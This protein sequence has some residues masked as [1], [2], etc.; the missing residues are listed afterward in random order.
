MKNEKFCF[1]KG[2]GLIALVG[3]LLVGFVLA[4]QMVTD[5]KTSINSRAGGGTAPSSVSI[6]VAG[7]LILSELKTKAA[8][9]LAVSG[10]AAA[11]TN[12]M[13]ALTTV[14]TQIGSSLTAVEGLI[15]EINNQKSEKEG[16]LIN[17]KADETAKKAV[18][19]TAKKTTKSAQTDAD[20]VAT[21]EEVYKKQLSD[22][23]ENLTVTLK[24]LS[25][26]KIKFVSAINGL[27][28]AGV[29]PTVKKWVQM[30]NAVPS[31]DEMGYLKALNEI[32]TETVDSN[33]PIINIRIT[34][35]TTVLKTSQ[36]VRTA[37]TKFVEDIASTVSSRGRLAAIQKNEGKFQSLADAKAT[38]DIAQ[39]AVD[40][41]APAVT[42]AQ[43]QVTVYES[44][45][46]EAT[47]AK[48]RIAILSTL[49]LETTVLPAGISGVVIPANMYGIDTTLFQSVQQE[50]DK[51]NISI[52]NANAAYTAFDS[53]ISGG[54]GASTAA[55]GAVTIVTPG[56]TTAAPGAVTI[57]T[58]GV[59][60]TCKSQ[61]GNWYRDVDCKALADRMKTAFK[62]GITPSDA[63]YWKGR[64]CCIGV[65]AVVVP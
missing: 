62:D 31:G 36:P 47:N 15:T 23:Q 55:P 34:A 14:T 17:A 63:K 30:I 54:I 60:T 32:S 46:T 21:S 18:L 33:T 8:P 48:N 52:T 12:A 3:V 24:D 61:G 53:T 35:F 26:S 65:K 7:T 64:V 42:L 58:P 56:V 1:S 28:G 38:Q 6:P 9:V 49:A 43:N 41:T 10:I 5:T 40:D 59:T 57:V 50:I 2:T 29:V 16:V 25:T 11:Q 20:S 37:Y 27:P 39:K 4:N 13:S 51:V 22:A 44:M 45:V 19:E